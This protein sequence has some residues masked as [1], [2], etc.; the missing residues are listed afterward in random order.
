MA[1]SSE[2]VGFDNAE[3]TFDEVLAAELINSLPQ[4]SAAL[5]NLTVIPMGTHT[6]RIPVLSALPTAQ[7]L[8]ADQEIKPKSAT[9]WKNVMLQAEEIAVIV[10][11]SENV[12]ADSSIDVVSRTTQLI[13]QEFGRVLDAAV[14]FGEGAPASYPAGGIFGAAQAQGTVVA[15]SGAIA[16]DLNDMFG[17]VEEL[18]HDVTDVFADRALRTALRGQKDG[19]GAPIYVPT[20]GDPNVGYIYGVPTAYPLGWDKSK[21]TAIAL[22]DSCAILGLRSDVKTKILT[23]AN[24]TG[25]GSLAER[26]SIAIRAT[27]RVAFQLADPVSVLNDT[28]LLPISAL[29]PVTTP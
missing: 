8:T 19:N 16:D 27:M 25:F 13:V 17:Q 2:N 18:G 9:A 22:D 3:A 20:E 15:G 7:F 28:P 29:A 11:I 24:I 21:A 1:V 10:P 4:S 14:F 12:I 23:E 26:D 5:A 6:E